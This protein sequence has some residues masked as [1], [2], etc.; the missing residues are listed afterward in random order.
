MLTQ[1]QVLRFLSGTKG[2]RY[3]GDAEPDTLDTF[4]DL[5]DFA[6]INLVGIAVVDNDTVLRYDKKNTPDF[7]VRAIRGWS[8][9]PF[10]ADPDVVLDDIVVTIGTRILQL[11]EK[12]RTLCADP[13]APIRHLSHQ[14]ARS[15]GEGKA[16]VALPFYRW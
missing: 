10:N 6:D 4:D 3:T 5:I 7:E 2:V 9:E 14:H 11:P 13:R 8:R 12:R 16:H 1:D 15:R